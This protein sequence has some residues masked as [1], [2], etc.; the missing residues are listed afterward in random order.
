[1]A[2][3]VHYEVF[4]RKT[5][6]SGWTLQQA[7]ESRDQAM[8]LAEDMLADKR[9][10]SVRVTKETLDL[11]TMEFQSVTLITKGAAEPVR[12]KAARD[13]RSLMVCT[14]PADLYAPHARELIGRVLEDWL[15]RKRV[16]AF[17]LLHRPDL[18]ETLEASGVELQH[19]V[20]KVAVPESQA[21]GQ[22][23]HE[24]IRHYQKLIEK[25]SERVIKAGRGDAFPNLER[26][27]LGDVARR[28]ID[29]PDRAF[30][31]GGAVAGALAKAR[32]WRAKFEVLMNLADTAP[33]EPGPAALV[34]VALEQAAS[35]ILALREGLAD[36]LGPSL[37]LGGQLAALARVAAPQEVEMLSKAD[38][39]LAA[40]IPPSEGPAQRLARHMARGQYRLLAAALSR[41][42]LRELMGPRR[43]RPTDPSAEIDILRALAM[44]LT[45]AAGRF[46]TLEEAQLAFAERSKALVAADFVEAYVGKAPTPLDEA[47]LLVRLC[48]NVTGASAKRSAAR[49]LAAS[50]TALRFERSLR[51]GDTGAGQRLAILADL[52]ARVRAC[53]LGDKDE[54]EICEALGRVGDAVDA[55][56][57]VTA[58]IARAPVPVVQRL[59]LLLRMACAQ[60][61]PAGPAADRARAE[62][63]RLLRSPDAR[64]AMTTDPAALPTLRPLLQAAGLAA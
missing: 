48:E 19:A 28:L 3:P 17:E 20:Q 55:A 5:A 53:D 29:S 13:D 23:V 51:E 30:L 21:T 62:A 61:C 59:G 45:A 26:E 4:A 60:A 31:I 34:H 10:V 43:L 57:K 32:G 49:W 52:Q 54:A 41:R 39:Q 50:I 37:D 47:N 6:Q 63:L 35:E 14:G 27:P 46:L 2:G 8:Q 40:V 24:I 36:V 15:G 11:E 9:A 18:V 44:V 1:M 25:A 38:A 58:Q 16:T 12:P 22:P 56:G 64:R 7:S 42:V 33:E